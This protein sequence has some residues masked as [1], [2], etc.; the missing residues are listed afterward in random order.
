MI[1]QLEKKAALQILIL[2]QKSEKASRTDLRNNINA[3]IRTVYSALEILKKLGL[4]EEE[5]MDSFP[6]TIYIKLT[7]KGHRVALHLSEIEKILREE[8]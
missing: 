3:N 2:L 6:F 5:A 4:I 1:E 8:N 7:E